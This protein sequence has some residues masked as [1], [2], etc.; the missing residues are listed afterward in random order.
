MSVILKYN[1]LAFL[2]A[3]K[4]IYRLLMYAATDHADY[5]SCSHLLSLLHE[6]YYLLWI[7]NES[8][9]SVGSLFHTEKRFMPYRYLVT[10]IR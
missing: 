4:F 1:V 7:R 8:F 3:F 9:V 6:I 2:K 5:G 10:H